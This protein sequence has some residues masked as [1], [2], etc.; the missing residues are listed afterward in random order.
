MQTPIT[1]TIAGG[2]KITGT[3]ADELL[4]GGTGN[5][6]I[7]SNGG[8]D[9]INGG[10]GSDTAAFQANES[11]YSWSGTASDFML[12]P[13]SG[14]GD[15]HVVNVETLQF[16]DATVAT[17]SL[18][19]STIHTIT[20]TGADES[21]VGTG[22]ND[23]IISNGGMDTID[24]GA[25]T[26]TVAML[27]TKSG[28]SW[29]GAASDFIL[30][31]IAGGGDKHVMNDEFVQFKDMTVSTASLF[32][33]TPTPPPTTVSGGSGSGSSGSGSSGS[34]S[35]GSGSSGSGLITTVPGGA[36]IIHMGANETY[37][38]LSA[39]L[40][41]ASNGD[42][43]Q[44]DAGT[45][46]NDTATITKSVTIQG[47]GG[48]AHFQSSGNIANGKAILI[49]DAASLTLQNL[50]LSG[51]AVSDGNG[52]G[53]RYEAG[54]LTIQ[55]SFFHDNQDGIL[56][57]AVSGGKISV[58]HSEFLNNGA[59][60]SQTHQLYAGA[61]SSLTVTN[62]S[63]IDAN[64]GID[65]KSRAATSMITGNSFLDSKTGT[66]SYEVDLPNGGNATIS[67]NSFYKSADTGN[68]ATIHFG[69]ELAGASGNLLVDHNNIWSDRDPTS[70]V[71]NQT[72]SNVT[73]TNNGLQST[74][75]IPVDVGHGTV[76][77]N[78]SLTG[79]APDPLH[80]F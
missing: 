49:D 64:G 75:S 56:G 68:R 69:G 55:N 40:G 76:S 39:A 34:G 65:V 74:V 78:L 36:H 4:T 19:G 12:H 32:A 61:I 41:A 47:V 50:E 63:F 54:T 57:G 16:K 71:L 58:D 29:S 46:L 8:A 37:H 15:K 26:D 42:V 5:D 70:V 67:G 38:T 22:G 52:A 77:G 17:T 1:T 72:Q 23:L 62:S 45:Y 25:G 9:T 35:S 59:G 6:L 21:L 53:I 11:G 18:F 24:A 10:A 14:G 60:D 79:V 2:L 43:I 44:V 51:A 66:T 7:I 13:I 27:S 33:S 28:Y 3:G 48:L 31:P 30:H 20:G 80:L 73:V